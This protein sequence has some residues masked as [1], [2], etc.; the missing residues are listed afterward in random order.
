MD[1]T[2]ADILLLSWLI[3]AY[4]WI[5]TAMLIYRSYKDSKTETRAINDLKKHVQNKTDLGV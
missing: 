2:W 5:D 4:I 1:T 3:V